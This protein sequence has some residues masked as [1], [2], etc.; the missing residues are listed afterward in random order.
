MTKI[1]IVDDEEDIRSLI[2]D[3]LRDEGYETLT[4]H[5]D[6]EAITL[7]QKEKPEAV[8]LD[9]W[10]EGSE[11]DGLGILKKIIKINHACP[12]IMMSGH[13]NIE[14]AVSCI[15]YGAYDFIEKPFQADKLLVTLKR[16]IEA[17]LLKIENQEL[18]VQIQNNNSDFHG[19][20][21][22]I[23]AVRQTIERA[24]PSNSRIFITG[25]A[26]TGK[27]VAARM[28]HK[29]SKRAEHPYIA[30]NCA[31]L[32]PNHLEL[33]LF[34]EED[35]ATGRIK[36]GVFEAAHMGTLYFDEIADMPLETQSKMMR[37][38]QDQQFTRKGGVK[39]ITV[40]V[41]IIS[42]T[43]Q[44]IHHLMNIQKFRQD[45]FYRLSVVPIHLPSLAERPEDIP[46]L[47]DHFMQFYA[48]QN[49]T[50]KRF[51]SEDAMATLQHYP[52]PGNVRQLKNAIE[53]LMIMA[54][55]DQSVPI[56]TEMLPPEIT[57]KTPNIINENTH[58]EM[59]GKP[60]REAREIF[61]R[62]YLLS[63]VNRFGG[64]ISRTAHFIGMERSAL[65]RKLKMLGIAHNDRDPND[66]E[67]AEG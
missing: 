60:L 49:K 50:A 57:Q 67:Q 14:T 18:K 44:D 58:F 63:Q 36:K 41:R 66:K 52:W 45:L 34:G 28:L 8:I 1:L 43:N 64:N 54:E 21:Q 32:S 37:V 30:I 7:F 61:E 16:A 20:S 62:E 65:H 59:M 25:A 29:L 2:A 17:S 53:W 22:A 42:S 4:A 38:L 27:E 47:C 10:L 35:N 39:P 11:Q 56:S 33:E 6:K 3:I 46:V 15:Q 19:I 40:D 26:G 23:L 24:A 31:H 13:G 48:E 5:N 12:V 55:G 9:I 51:F